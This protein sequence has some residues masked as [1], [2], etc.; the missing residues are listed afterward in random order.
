MNKTTLLS[1]G[2]PATVVAAF[3]AGKAAIGPETAEPAQEKNK[4]SVRTPSRISSSPSYS[5]T[6]GNPAATKS[7][8]IKFTRISK[9]E[10]EDNFGIKKIAQIDDPLRR[11]AL[12]LSVIEQMDSEDFERV[13][14][15]FRA[16]D[17]TRSRMTEYTQLL[18]AWA[19]KDAP[20][21]L[22]Y[23]AANTNGDFAKTTIL[24]S[25]AT[26]DPYAAIDW[27]KA[28]H[29]GSGANPLMVGVIK[30]IAINDIAQ[31]T[32][33]LQELPFSRERGEAMS[34]MLK[35]VA[36][37]EQDVALAWL[38]SIEDEKL[39]AGATTRLVKELAI[40]DPEGMA[41]W[42]RNIEDEESRARSIKAVVDQWAEQ[43]IEQAKTWVGGLDGNEKMSA[44]RGMIG[45]YAK[46][47]A[48][49][50]ADWMDSMKGQEGHQDLVKGYIWSTAMSRQ[51]EAA[52]A[53]I[54]N[55][56]NADNQM[57]YYKN[58]LER[59]SDA[60]P[61]ATAKWLDNN[62]KAIPED[63]QKSIRDRIGKIQAGEKPS[64]RG[65]WWRG[66][67]SGGGR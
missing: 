57:R 61:E 12:L 28:N 31:A 11:S 18:H 37:Q 41:A 55:I 8:V 39:R 62:P 32:E 9:G 46:K 67:S 29:E 44:A 24:A 34:Q 43:D 63:M 15:D 2:W 20:A 60:D 42:V 14:A 58:G 30:G 6:M 51:P 65:S 17:M 35:H 4:V 25:W 26:D 47:D 50:A 10:Y 33:L 3:I 45:E 19:Q 52:M 49:A 27:A 56:D 59:W 38:D 64:G 23:A 53:Q 40:S 5:S 22:E 1:I 36:S 21:A 16:L 48:T 66:R 13:V 7:N 54:A